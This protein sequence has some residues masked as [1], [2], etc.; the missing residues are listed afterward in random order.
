MQTVFI[1]VV[2]AALLYSEYRYFSR[3][4]FPVC[5]FPAL[6]PFFFFLHK[7]VIMPTFS[8]PGRARHVAALT[9][10][11]VILP[12]SST[13]RVNAAER[14]ASDFTDPVT[15]ISSYPEELG[16]KDGPYPFGPYGTTAPDLSAGMGVT[17]A[18]DEQYGPFEDLYAHY[19]GSGDG[20]NPAIPAYCVQFDIL[21]D[22]SAKK[23]PGTSFD[24]LTEQQ[25]RA[26]ALALAFS[27]DLGIA[28]Y[29]QVNK[30]AIPKTTYLS[31][32]GMQQLVWNIAGSDENGYNPIGSSRST[33]SGDDT[34]AADFPLLTGQ[35]LE[36]A[37]LLSQETGSYDT[38]GIMLNTY[39]N[40]AGNVISAAS[41][42]SHTAVLDGS[43][44]TLKQESGYRAE[45]YIGKNINPSLLQITCPRDEVSLHYSPESGMLQISVPLEK[46]SDVST[47]L[48]L[49]HLLPA[50]G[51]SAVFFSGGGQVVTAHRP[52][53][54]LHSTLIHLAI[55]RP[56]PAVTPFDLQIQKKSVSGTPLAG[57]IFSVTYRPESGETTDADGN[58]ATER[59]WYLKTGPDGT[60]G[61]ASIAPEKTSS[62]LYPS[63]AAG[64]RIPAGTLTVREVQ[65][66]DGYTPDPDEK[67]IP[68]H[69]DGFTS[70][71]RFEAGPLVFAN[72]PAELKDYSTSAAWSVSGD[73]RKEISAETVREAES[74]GESVLIQDAI[75]WKG[76]STQ[77]VYQVH[78]EL[79]NANS[80]DV[81]AKTWDT[82]Y[83]FSEVNGSGVM[84]FPVTS[85]E[86]AALGDNSTWQLRQTLVLNGQIA[87]QDTGDQERIHITHPQ[88]EKSIGQPS[89]SADEIFTYSVSFTVPG[90]PSYPCLG[91]SLV[92]TLPSG[93]QLASGTAVLSENGAVLA[94]DLYTVTEETGDSD[95]LLISLSEKALSLYSGR[96]LTLVYG[97][98]FLISTPAA[99]PQVNH[100]AYTASTPGFIR[101]LTDEVSVYTGSATFIKQSGSS[102]PVAGAVFRLLG[103]DGTP[104]RL[105]R[106]GAPDGSEYIAVSGDDGRFTFTGLS[107]G[108]YRIQ[109]I[110]APDGHSLL[111]SDFSIQ[112]ADGALSADSPE[113]IENPESLTLHAGGPGITPVLF[114]SAVPAAALACSFMRRRKKS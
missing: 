10:A 20:F 78:T 110:Q 11:A 76:A 106:T 21:L 27:P 69:G 94:S 74:A 60:A 50:S 86:L 68:S 99:T 24:L 64:C 14:T 7:E 100:V 17:F 2:S 96:Q 105:H 89:H 79:F 51:D 77:E 67:T 53:L 1:L 92:D 18:P 98:R 31:W 44:L 43:S 83:R 52:K 101:T 81:T 97:A 47:V 41:Y 102:T 80:P 111:T 49:S 23:T 95:R 19:I 90:D 39:R 34:D 16:G 57:A 112:I 33:V 113:I 54:D 71:V 108:T 28:D 63:D 36:N 25:Q 3:D 45:V 29:S 48:T 93:L 70:P 5:H 66:P 107:D 13:L 104:Y 30:R 88:L 42:S 55:E 35:A 61:L 73:V 72:A 109:E 84:N 75:I 37:K 65:A 12:L 58:R 26:I 32:L 9:F 114:V 46:A 15:I 22:G 6:V 103:A 85:E 40:V 91:A 62:P 87:A 8:A 56:K 38:D 82:Q 59:T 4:V